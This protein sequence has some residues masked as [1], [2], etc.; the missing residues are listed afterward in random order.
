MRITK[1]A[2]P[3]PA[4]WRYNPHK[5]AGAHRAKLN[6]IHSAAPERDGVKVDRCEE[7]KDNNA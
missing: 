2:S 3:A 6:T 7:Q 5:K 4:G 1:A